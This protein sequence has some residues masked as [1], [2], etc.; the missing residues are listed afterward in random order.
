MG[1]LALLAHDASRLT[2]RLAAVEQLLNTTAASSRVVK[3]TWRSKSGTDGDL[4]SATA[5]PGTL[6]KRRAKLAEPVSSLLVRVSDRLA[7]GYPEFNP[8]QPRGE[9]GRWSAVGSAE[10]A[11]AALDNIDNAL[12]ALQATPTVAAANRFLESTKQVLSNIVGDVLEDADSFWQRVL[13]VVA[14]AVQ[15]ASSFTDALGIGA[16]A[17]VGVSAVLG[18]QAG[19]AVAVSLA[20][21]LTYEKWMSKRDQKR[22]KR[23]SK[24]TRARIEDLEA[25]L[26]SLRRHRRRR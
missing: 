16:A 22:L 23:E 19:V 15:V 24:A 3:S 4:F 21:W 13:K 2:S 7:K 18:A 1:E 26:E 20:G 10:V 8:D 14:A 12:K 6:A 25:Q 9:G 11:S 17:G 5:M